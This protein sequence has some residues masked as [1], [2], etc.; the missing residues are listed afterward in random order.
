MENYVLQFIEKHKLNKD[1]FFDA[2]GSPVNHDLMK[3]IDKL[4]A[5]NTTPC[6]TAGH[7]IR[8]RHSH[9]VV[10][11]TAHIAFMKR[12]C[13]DGSIYIAGSIKKQI[14]KVGMTTEKI[15]SRIS[16]LN[17]RKVGN[18]DDWVAL[19]TF[20][21][22]KVNFIELAIHKELEKYKVSGDMYGD[23]ES[24]ELFR[25]S[26]EKANEIA[27]KAF[28]DKK[29]KIIKASN[30]LYS[31]E[32]YNFKNIVPLNTTIKTNNSL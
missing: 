10:C 20:E 19:K 28:K 4:F 24:N 14:T 17:S 31:K 18:T 6:Q 23:N 29:H 25:C 32:K 16:K 3:S 8:D 1:D 26:F 15:E 11:N 12:S 13:E 7:I 22:I 2:K 21:C 27:E 9:C 5:Y 30:L